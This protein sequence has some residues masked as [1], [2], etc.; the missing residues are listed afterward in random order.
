MSRISQ[1][2]HLCDFRNRLL[3]KLDPFPAKSLTNR[4]RCP[5]DI[6]AGPGETVDDAVADGVG[7]SCKNNRCREASVFGSQ[8][9]GCCTY[10][11][12]VNFEADKFGYELRKALCRPFRPSN[13]DRDV[14]ALDIMQLSQTLAKRFEIGSRSRGRR[15]AYETYPRDFRWLLC[16]GDHTNSKVHHDDND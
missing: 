11:K 13:L 1:H 5:C 14:L 12:E 6:S 8:S 7:D 15:G 9:T 3:Q 16:V 10:Q 2:G 4:K